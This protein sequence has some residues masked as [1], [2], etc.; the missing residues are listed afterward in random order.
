MPRHNNTIY[1]NGAETDTRHKQI[2]Y[3]SNQIALNTSDSRCRNGGSDERN[4]N[5]CIRYNKNFFLTITWRDA[6][7]AEGGW[8]CDSVRWKQKSFEKLKFQKEI[9]RIVQNSC[10]HLYLFRLRCTFWFSSEKK[11]KFLKKNI[12]VNKFKKKISFIHSFIIGKN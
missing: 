3:T 6:A 12:N 10:S 8:V 11:M 5:I 7:D 4:R 2:S 1:I 9:F